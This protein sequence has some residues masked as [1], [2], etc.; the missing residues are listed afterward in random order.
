MTWIVNVT[1][2]VDDV[3]HGRSGE[4]LSGVDERVEPEAHALCVAR[5]R[6]HLHDDVM[7]T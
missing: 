5:R 3:H 6:R 2:V 7:R 4:P 1:Y